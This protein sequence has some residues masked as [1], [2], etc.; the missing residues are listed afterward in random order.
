M[1]QASFPECELYAS[2][3]RLVAGVDEAG[4][5]PLAGPVVAAAVI[6]PVDWHHPGIRDSKQLSPRKR[7]ELYRVIGTHALAWSWSGVEPDEI[8]RINILQASRTAMKKA[9]ETLPIIPDYLL[10]DGTHTIAAD[11]EQCA[12][13]RGDARSRVIA[14]ASIMAKVVRDEIMLKYHPLYPR[15]NFSRNK[16]YG[17]HEHLCALKDRG[18]CRIHRTSFRRVK[19]E[20]GA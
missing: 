16:G 15:Y 13:P 18:P 5:G 20:E 17:T 1:P 3:Y 12:L 9:V 10:V 4:R 11:V 7:K 8:D 6:L 2:G 14:A 19:P